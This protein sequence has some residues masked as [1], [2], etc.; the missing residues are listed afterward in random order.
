MTFQFL[1]PQG[2]LLEGEEAHMGMQCQ[3]PQCGTAFIIPTIERPGQAARGGSAQTAAPSDLDLAPLDDG[4]VDEPAAGGPA[5]DEQALAGVDPSELVA[6]E[7]GAAVDA[8]QMLHI[9]CPN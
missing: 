3:C 5:I 8:E 4:D 6:T 9:P 7:L 2:H 1:C